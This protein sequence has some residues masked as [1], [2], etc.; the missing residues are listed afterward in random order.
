MYAAAIILE[1]DAI[2]S[3]RSA[4]ARA[5]T[6]QLSASG[7]AQR[8]LDRELPGDAFARIEI[9]HEAVGMLYLVDARV[10]RVQLDRADVH[11]TEEAARSL[12]QNRVPSALALLDREP[13]H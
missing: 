9:E 5:P 13:V 8:R 4:S 6:P 10:P 2:P 3:P 11:Q 12:A 1:L 7:A